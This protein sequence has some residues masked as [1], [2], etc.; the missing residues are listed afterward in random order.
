M[1]LS[2]HDAYCEGFGDGGG[3]HYSSHDYNHNAVDRRNDGGGYL[4]HQNRA[5]QKARVDPVTHDLAAKRSAAP[6]AHLHDSVSSTDRSNLYGGDHTKRSG[7]DS[8]HSY[9]GSSSNQ[10]DRRSTETQ[11]A[12]DHRLNQ[13][14]ETDG[15]IHRATTADVSRIG[16]Q[17]I[18]QSHERG[19]LERQMNDGWTGEMGLRAT[20]GRGLRRGLVGAGIGAAI[21]LIPALGVATLGTPLT[22][23]LGAIFTA[24][25]V[26]A[27]GGFLTGPV[28]REWSNKVGLF[29]G[30]GALGGATF[31]LGSLALGI[32]TGGASLAATTLGGAALGALFG[33][34]LAAMNGRAR[35]HLHMAAMADVE[36]R[37]WA[38][39]G[40]KFLARTRWAFAGGIM[41]TALGLA[42]PGD[43]K[44]LYGAVLGDFGSDFGTISGFSAG[45][46]GPLYRRWRLKVVSNRMEQLLNGM[47]DRVPTDMEYSEMMDLWKHALRHKSLAVLSI[48]AQSGFNALQ[49]RVAGKFKIEGNTLKRAESRENM[50]GYDGKAASAAAPVAAATV[51][52]NTFAPVADTRQSARN[53]SSKMTDENW[54]E[55]RDAVGPYVEIHDDYVT[56]DGVPVGK[57][58]ADRIRAEYSAESDKGAD[59][60][61]TTRDSD[62]FVQNAVGSAGSKIKTVAADAVDTAVDKGKSV[63]AKPTGS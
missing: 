12:S 35:Y 60:S 49:R 8:T 1:L 51:A 9:S 7:A 33:S 16:D 20:L 25:S 15:R 52:D 55:V 46:I 29:G 47:S 41:G 34:G 40:Y 56:K 3:D 45:Y 17:Y 6:D 44:E 53:E 14:H 38:K 21:G 2:G 36:G 19:E 11:S 5:R 31:G 13:I 39:H 63:F 23:G 30:I 59:E 28:T 48:D 10:A 57:D 4:S 26:G 43:N 50:A 27:L 37:F 32:S 61:V 62:G 22:A 54:D 18:Y 58:E 24:A 42:I